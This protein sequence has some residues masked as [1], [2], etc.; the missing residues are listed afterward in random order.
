MRAELRSGYATSGWCLSLA[1][2]VSALTMPGLTPIEAMGQDLEMPGPQEFSGPGSEFT[3]GYS[4]GAFSDSVGD[5]SSGY[6]SD[7]SSGG[8]PITSNQGATIPG[9]PGYGSGGPPASY[10]GSGVN[11]SPSLGAHLRVRYNTESYGQNRGN[12]DIG[13]MKLYNRGDS[14]LFIDGQVTLN[15]ESR[16]GY[17][18]GAGY[19]WLTLPLFP[20]SPDEE[21]MMGVSFWHDGQQTRNDHFYSQLGVSLEFLGDRLD[22][23]ANGYAPIGQ[24]SLDTPLTPTG[25]LEF[26]EN[27][28]LRNTAGFR[29]TALTAGELEGAARLADL[30]AWAF[31]GG[32][33]LAGDGFDTVGAKLGVRG[34][35]TPD[36]LLQL[37]VTDDDL[38]DTNV[39]FS[40]VWFI[41]R[42]RTNDCPTGTMLD[43]MREPVLRNDYIAVRETRL[44]GGTPVTDPTTG[45]ARRFEHV[46]LTAA[47][48]GDGTIESPL[49]SFDTLPAE[50]EP[51]N[52]ILVASR[53][54]SSVDTAGALQDDQ[55]VLGLGTPDGGTTPV[56][57]ELSTVELG[58]I[59]VPTPDYADPTA[60]LPLI[61]RGAAA[62]GAALSLANNNVVLNMRVSGG[63]M[64]I[65]A[66]GAQAGDVVLAGLE[67]S[68]T[69]SDGI[70]IAPT[71]DTADFNVVID[72]VEF[73]DVGGNDIDVD[74]AGTTNPATSSDRILI[75]NI[76]SR[77]VR[78]ESLRVA[79]TGS[80]QEVNI[81][82]YDYDGGTTGD[83]GMHFENVGA[84][85]DI[86]GNTT[87]TGSGRGL[88]FDGG[89]G[90]ATVAASVV[91]DNVDGT[92]VEARGVTG[93]ITYNGDIMNSAGNSVVID[94]GGGNV[95]FSPTADITDEGAGIVVSNNTAGMI[96]FQ[97][98]VDIDVDD[99]GVN[100]LEINGNDASVQIDFPDLTVATTTGTGVLASGNGVLTL[101]AD[102][103]DT[104]G[105]TAINLSDISI[106]SVAIG[107]VDVTAAGSANAIRL[108]NLEGAGPVVIGSVGATS[109]INGSGDTVTIVD[110]PN[111]T[112]R[113][114]NIA[115]SGGTALRALYAEDDVTS[116][117]LTLDDVETNDGVTVNVDGN[118]VGPA[119][120]SIRNSEINDDVTITAQHNGASA[121]LNASID[122]NEVN[123]GAVTVTAMNEGDADIS[124]NANMVTGRLAINA[125]NSG[126]VEFSSQL[127]EV[128]N[129][130]DQV[131]YAVVI[132]E[133]VNNLDGRMQGD[134]IATGDNIAFSLNRSGGN[135]SSVRFELS[136]IDD[137]GTMRGNLFEN[138]S[139][140]QTTAVFNI[141]E[142]VEFD[143]GILGANQ[144]TNRGAGP[145]VLDITAQDAATMLDLNL[146]G[147][148][149]ESNGADMVGN[150]LLNRNNGASFD[151]VERG[152][153][154][155]N[156]RNEGTTVIN[157]PNVANDFG[158]ILSDEFTPPTITSP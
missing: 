43:R 77:D 66:T 123:G 144:F 83:A 73:N 135:T 120:V 38:Y 54:G 74:A 46:D 158:D 88:F 114:T 91:V 42:T 10:S 12:V 6:S 132:G 137:N 142:T 153:T 139:G 40:A 33:G 67:I 134:E 13:S 75:S 138:D 41:G 146:M 101:G 65:D 127:N 149:V 28:L 31:A 154:L 22:F 95:T 93:V 52:T 136:E 32:Y 72:D 55:Q 90:N 5:F 23:R 104:T 34:Y 9:G 152:D 21:K 17:N 121:S 2:M 48:N 100:G 99:A 7:F 69:A 26:S 148:L 80:N 157:A 53:D 56:S 107:E 145:D 81:S 78:G 59:T 19:R 68:E 8:S 61:A 47:V 37:A 50:S 108:I 133:D 84:A 102:S 3:P 124:V 27:F 105:G 116:I 24:R 156:T 44:T 92:A 1:L 130:N 20:F 140:A 57:Y 89:A 125:L 151:I 126:D 71:A 106:N 39:V 45:E 82:N 25:E 109:T 103:V 113:N 16:V 85:T 35:A 147:A 11:Y 111:V 115:S 76:V 63:D 150:I 18:L 79:N 14:A 129:L 29:E 49:N 51:G 60:P 86:T 97:G 155:G 70:R 141:T 112:L 4:S 122:N 110:A 131:A 15:E 118:N 87:L 119:L 143:L 36:L 64:G 62:P 58:T 117:G 98:A 96:V 30:D 128:T 94:S